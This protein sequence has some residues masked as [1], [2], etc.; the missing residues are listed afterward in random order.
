MSK[1]KPGK[2]QKNKS[3][4]FKDVIG[5]FNR[6]PKKLY[7][8]KQLAADAGVHSEAE[9]MLV[10]NLL[11]DLKNQDF[12]EEVERGKFRLKLNEKY[13]TGRIEITQSGSAYVISEE[14]ESDVFI[15]QHNVRGAMNNDTVKVYLLPTRGR[16][17]EGEVIQIV[18]RYKEEF[19]G[20]IELSKN[21][22]FLVNDNNR[23]S[24]DIFIPITKLNGAKH[25]D[26]AV[27]KVIEWSDSGKNPTGEIVRVLGKPGENNTEMN[28]IMAEYGLPVEFPPEVE[29][30]AKNIPLEISAEE[31][32]KRNDFR[33]KTTFTIDPV[34]AKDFDDALSIIKL[35]DGNWEIGVHIADVA[36]YVKPGSLLDKEAIERATSVYLVDRCVPMLPEVLS[37]HV[38]SLRP[39]EEKLCFSAVFVMN[40]KA[41]ILNQ[42]FGRTIILSDRR[43]SY[44]EAQTILE[45]GSG[46]FHSELITLNNLA[47]KLR[48]QR[49]KNGS[50]AFEKSEVKFKLDENGKP[51]GVYFK[52]AK[53]SN[54]LIEDFMLLAN[55]KVAEYC[56]KIKSNSEKEKKENAKHRP[57][58]YRIHD[59]PNPD[60]LQEFAGFITR[61]GY[62]L[63]TTN[64]LQIA[65]S[66]NKL[67][68]D[69]AGKREANMIEQL[70]IRTM[71][72]AIYSTENVGHY[73]L[74]FDY[75]THF[76]SPIRRYPDVLVHRLLN[77][78]LAIDQGK[79]KPNDAQNLLNVE[80]LELLCK[81]SSDM[82]KLAAEA[83]RSSIK[84]KQVE[85]LL[86]KTGQEFEGLISGVTE[87]GLYVEIIENHCEGMVRVK[88]LTDD[89]YTFDDENFCFHGRR[90]RKFYQ[91]GDKVLIKIKKTDLLR[92]QVDFTLLAKIEEK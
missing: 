76:T 70:A 38:C 81:H 42:W 3:A 40:D 11:L 60:K 5:I 92:K 82:E 27:A 73:G 39:K 51:L 41:E 45:S 61:F 35:A 26:K 89:I 8:Y 58:V 16:K 24:P 1:K 71:A 34:D 29:D 90:T 4:L 23:N 7:N 22:A 17:P 52:E 48:E 87:W 54:K 31:I 43:F 30:E 32:S 91:L 85:F 86:D 77:Y 84:Y 74:A 9:R 75:Y 63:K 12:L 72:K 55:R 19:V 65:K 18:K 67:L 83:E 25:G 59:N 46:D 80:S 47:K 21:F 57:M 10:N 68:S 88:D 20:I 50:I 13:I 37:N 14:S 36:H 6:N 2:Q 66:M 79:S 78:Y 69:V 62:S 28:A 56:G 44:E 64:H 15:A 33:G 53:D 49:F